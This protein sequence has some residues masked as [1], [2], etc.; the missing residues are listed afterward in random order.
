MRY[1]LVGPIA[2]AALL[3]ACAVQPAANQHPVAAVEPPPPPVPPVA[4]APEP[5]KDVAP[6][7]DQG[8]DAKCRSYGLTHG[9]SD[10]A[11]CRAAL[12]RQRIIGLLRL[13]PKS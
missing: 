13:R 1:S 9:T 3:A 2:F 5:E 11:K 6:V 8:D 12:E 7:A 10:Y 4:V